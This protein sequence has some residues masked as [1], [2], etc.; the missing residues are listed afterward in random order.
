MKRLWVVRHP[1]VDAA[2]RCY[3]RADVKTSWAP[4]R[5][6]E[7]VVPQLP[8]DLA[9]VRSSPSSRA[10]DAAEAIAR[11]L[12]V[13]LAVDERVAEL[14]HGDWEGRTW[15]EI[16]KADREAMDA[17]GRDWELQGPPGGES[18][19]ELEAR[20]CAAWDDDAASDGDVLWVTH[21]GVIRALW[22]VE[23]RL[24]WPEAMSLDVAPLAVHGVCR[25]RRAEPKP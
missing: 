14:S 8:G 15:N 1:P 20:V 22:R 25:G 17:W 4:A 7:A 6:A 21:A 10:R 2:G 3:G 18:A 5:S 12:G 16:V 9:L 23:Q 24:S 19:R 11:H 13:P